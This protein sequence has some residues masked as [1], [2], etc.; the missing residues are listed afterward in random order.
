MLQSAHTSSNPFGPTSAS[1]NGGS[2]YDG[3]AFG[4]HQNGFRSQEYGSQATGRVYGRPAYPWC[5]DSRVSSQGMLP[6]MIFLCAL[7]IMTAGAPIVAQC[8]VSPANV[9]S[10]YWCVTCHRSAQFPGR[11]KL[12]GRSQ[13]WSYTESGQWRS[14]KLWRADLSALQAFSACFQAPTNS[15]LHAGVHT[16]QCPVLCGC[17]HALPK[18]SS[19]N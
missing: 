14:S 7:L 9:S 16:P 2:G 19:D 8:M 4:Q 17:M 13:S 15:A 3:S 10:I 1:S 5:K 18:S 6:A 11:W 12:P